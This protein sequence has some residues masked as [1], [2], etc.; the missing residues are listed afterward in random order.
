MSQALLCIKLVD[1]VDIRLDILLRIIVPTPTNH[2]VSDFFQRQLAAMKLGDALT[3]QA[4]LVHYHRRG[5]EDGWFTHW[6]C[7]G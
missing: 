7:Q 3:L 4:I 6:G 2:S 5:R 1:L